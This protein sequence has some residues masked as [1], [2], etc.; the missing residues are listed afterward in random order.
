MVSQHWYKYLF[1]NDWEGKNFA[2]LLVV[3]VKQT[4]GHCLD[5][6]GVTGSIPV[7]PTIIAQNIDLKSSR[8]IK[9]VFNCCDIVARLNALVFIEGRQ[10]PPGVP[11]IY[12]H[13]PSTDFLNS[14]V[15]HFVVSI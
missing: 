8:I 3:F 15:N 10:G 4:R 6:A 7:A 2:D 1:Q 13:K 9:I 11:G 5:T 14:N 12:I